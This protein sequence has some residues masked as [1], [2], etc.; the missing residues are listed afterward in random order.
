MIIII[1]VIIITIT[2]MIVI[3]VIIIKVITVIIMIITVIT[4]TTPRII[5]NFPQTDLAEFIAEINQDPPET[6]ST[7][8]TAT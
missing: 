1:I 3:I 8:V 7:S 4:V 5:F 2:I 6:I